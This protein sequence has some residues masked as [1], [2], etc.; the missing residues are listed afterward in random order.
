MRPALRCP[1]AHVPAACILSSLSSAHLQQRRRPLLFL[2][3]PPCCLLFPLGL[4]AAAIQDAFR[5][6]AARGASALVIPEFVPTPDNLLFGAAVA[7][8]DR[9]VYG[10]IAARR[11]WGRD[12]ARV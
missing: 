11:R 1:F 6:F 7:R 4:P 10:L 3:P 9:A 8:L 5:Y 2:T 12:G